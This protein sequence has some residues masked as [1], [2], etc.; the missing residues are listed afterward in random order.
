MVIGHYHRVDCDDVDEGS[1]VDIIEPGETFI[2]G[3]RE[4]VCSGSSIA[5]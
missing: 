4:K 2:M 3:K 5:Q 1:L